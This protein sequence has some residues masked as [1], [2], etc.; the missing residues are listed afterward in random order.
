MGDFNNCNPGKSSGHLHLLKRFV[1][2]LFINSFSD[3]SVCLS[4]IIGRS[5][6]IGWRGC[7]SRHNLHTLRM[8]TSRYFLLR[9]AV[10]Y[11]TFLVNKY[12][13][14]QIN[15]NHNVQTQ[16]IVMAGPPQSALPPLRTCGKASGPAHAH[17]HVPVKR[18]PWQ[19]KQEID[20]S[21][22]T[23]ASTFA[24]G[25]VDLIATHRVII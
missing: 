18:G 23:P 14:T 24:P 19:L 3:H 8:V 22:Q 6:L 13:Q 20:S 10:E 1:M 2:F 5:T 25:I 7:F 12:I 16:L 11:F 4:D 21:K 15:N 9:C 17:V